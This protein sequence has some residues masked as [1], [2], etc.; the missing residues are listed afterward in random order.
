MRIGIIAEGRGDLAVISNILMG[1]LGVDSEDIQFLRP[2][3]SLDETDLHGQPEERF[4]NWE[5]VKEE[6]ID[7]S[8]INEFLGSPLE[9]ERLVVIHID[10]AEAELPGFDIARPSAKGGGYVAE[11]HRRVTAKLEEW[12]NGRGAGR[13]RYAIA[14]EETDAWVLTLYSEKDTT[15]HRNAKDALHKELNRPNRFS[16][17]ARKSLFASKIYERYEK[18][19]QDFRKRR[20]LKECATRNHSLQLFIDSLPPP[21]T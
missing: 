12:L 4:S 19:S 13:T 17:K 16:E 9:E 14:V 3:Y 5:L 8:R 2:E 1:H 15:A 20:K 6:C 7:C 10:T 18:L 21:P 11:L